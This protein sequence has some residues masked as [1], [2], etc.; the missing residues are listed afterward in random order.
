MVE[1]YEDHSLTTTL[2][3]D[4]IFF[5]WRNA[6]SICYFSLMSSASANQLRMMNFVNHLMYMCNM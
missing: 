3:K 4:K 2:H 6:E 5:G 1:F